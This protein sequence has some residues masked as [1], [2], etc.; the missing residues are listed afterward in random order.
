M[1]LETRR[2]FS[3]AVLHAVQEQPLTGSAG[4]TEHGA[5]PVI[6]MGLERVPS[7]NVA[8][9]THAFLVVSKRTLPFAGRPIIPPLLCVPNP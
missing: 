8:R 7:F 1:R 6:A 3:S 2:P 4:V 5:R 9:T